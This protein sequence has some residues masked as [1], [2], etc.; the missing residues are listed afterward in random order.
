MSKSTSLGLV[1]VVAGSVWLGL[2]IEPCRDWLAWIFILAVPT[3][4][5]GGVVLYIR[6]SG[7]RE[8]Q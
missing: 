5:L 1:A 4:V 2:Q 6:C 7:K 8:R 3:V